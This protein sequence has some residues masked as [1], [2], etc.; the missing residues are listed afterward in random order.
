MLDVFPPYNKYIL[1][2]E[3]YTIFLDE[4]F[5]KKKLH[6][7]SVLVKRLCVIYRKWEAL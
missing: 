2:F 7:L 6:E 1:I 3:F 4:I 5:L